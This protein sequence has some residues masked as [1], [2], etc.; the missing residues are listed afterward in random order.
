[1]YFRNSYELANVL[2]YVRL[3]LL[4]EGREKNEEKSGN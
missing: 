3:F 2:G 4:I 1:M